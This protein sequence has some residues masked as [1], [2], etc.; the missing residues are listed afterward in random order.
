[1]H[2]VNADFD[3]IKGRVAEISE[4]S[5]VMCQI[6]LSQRRFVGPVEDT[7]VIESHGRYSPAA[8]GRNV[9]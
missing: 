4:K 2:V 5:V 1:M 6:T 3:E 9:M 8:A 7:K